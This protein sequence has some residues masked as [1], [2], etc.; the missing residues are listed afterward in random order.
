MS[1]N[2]ANMGL[3]LP[4]IGTDTGLTWE[5]SM[6][7]NS[8]TLDNHNHTAGQGNQIPP[9]G[10]NIN[11]S[12]PFNNQQATSLQAAV[13]QAQNSLITQKA[14]YVSGV[15]LYYNDGSGN[16]IQMTTGGAVN[17]T[18]SGISS[19]NATASFVASVLTVKANSTTPA[20]ISGGSVLIGNNVSNSKFLTLQPPNAM[21]ADYAVTLPALPGSQSFMSID[22]SGNMTGY[23]AVS[24]GIGTSNL[25]NGAVTNAKLAALNYAYSTS[26]GTYTTS[27]VVPAQI[28]NLSVSITTSGRPVMAMLGQIYG[29]FASDG[30]VDFSSTVGNTGT[31]SFTDTISFLSSQ[32]IGQ[33]G[34]TAIRIPGTS[35]SALLLLSAGVHTINVYAAV[36]GASST[37]LTAKELQLIVYEL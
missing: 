24:G 23:A 17:A 8:Q 34:G 29:S 18:S 22:A 37:L 9:A 3:I 15:D 4:T 20:N 5:Q 19:G 13:F 2:T 11:T 12:L 33:L 25:A 30:Y 1:T 16:V 36:S 21:A 27:S 28:T 6:N 31:I 32:Q 7:A 26:C 14:L 10:I 35:F